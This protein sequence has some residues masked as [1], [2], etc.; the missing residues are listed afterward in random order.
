MQ[1]PARKFYF[2]DVYGSGK[3]TKRQVTNLVDDEQFRLHQRVQFAMQPIA[4]DGA[5]ELAGQIHGGGEI[6]P[7][8]HFGYLHAQ[9]DR[10]MGLAHPGR[11]QEDQVSPFGKVAARGQLLD[12]P[13]VDAGLRGVVE[14][15]EPLEIRELSELK[16]QCYPL[17][18][19][20]LEFAVEQRA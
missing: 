4:I 2:S 12:Q 20:R 9:R 13:P 14:V 1:Y 10:Q 16:I 6:D 19:A 17:V 11:P 15:G 18:V 5:G 3:L 7:V 8:A